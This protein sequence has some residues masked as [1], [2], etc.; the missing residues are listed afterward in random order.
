MNSNYIT[1][2]LK[3]DIIENQE[4]Q[5]L[6]N[7]RDKFNTED[8]SNVIVKWNSNMLYSI[9]MEFVCSEIFYQEL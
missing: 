3:G 4:E 9:I 1:I 2:R 5:S 8:T 6:E 7:T